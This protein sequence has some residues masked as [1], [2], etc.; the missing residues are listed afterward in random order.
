L[1]TLQTG[2]KVE[3]PT[4]AVWKV[5]S[6]QTC[7]RGITFIWLLRGEYLRPPQLLLLSFLFPSST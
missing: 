4:I 1:R 3:I 5:G 2:R 6:F 7:K